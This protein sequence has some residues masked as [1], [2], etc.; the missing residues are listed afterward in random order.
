M[1]NLYEHFNCKNKDELYAM[2]K[3]EDN[4]VQSLLDFIEFAKADIKNKN[5]A[6]N[7][8]DILVDYVKSTTL[9]TKD[10]GTIIF[11]D[12]KN[13]PVHLKRTRLSRKSDIKD[14]IKEGLI[15]G[16]TR[17]FIAFS[18]ETPNNR[19]EQIK[20]LFENIGMKIV[21][22]LGCNEDKNTF[23]STSVGRSFYPTKS[24][25]LIHD[26]HNEYLKEDLSLKGK[27]ED[28]S[29][30][31]AINE[32][33]GLNAIN[34]L[35][36]IKETLKIGFQHHQQ[37]VFGIIIYDNDEKILSAEELFKG[38]TDSSLVDLKIIA[39]SLLQLEKV[40]GM[41]IFHNHP[42]GNPTPSNE[43]IALTTKVTQMCDVLGVELLDHFIVG[44]ERTLSFSE[45]I[46]VF[47]SGNI[48]YQDKVGNIR[49]VGEGS[50]DY[51]NN[52]GNLPKEIFDDYRRNSNDIRESIE[53][54]INNHYE[55]FVKAL[56]TI[57]KGIE[58]ENILDE[59]YDRFMDNDGVN[60]INDYF[61]DVL[62]D[63]DHENTVSEVV[64]IKE[65]PGSIL[66]GLKKNKE[67]IEYKDLKKDKEQDIVSL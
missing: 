45:E 60:L 64:K 57:E 58:D 52:N 8:P 44:K 23:I 42:S 14:T 51:G 66:E 26:S 6:I 28:F 46:G 17:A 30:H 43:D 3:N 10:A 11:V 48:R 22:T 47:Q 37:E 55:D 50:I 29:S 18:D 21:D 40:K 59:L 31:F 41:A 62:Y 20:S 24:F 53:Y 25:E 5:K 33:I 65:K 39:K 4:Q 32:I 54:I 15:S 36:K 16:G 38:A 12:T 63:L 61:D 49:N 27:Y 56:I 34:D 19:M 35:E 2:V 7:S 13:Q 9:P 67:K 1:N